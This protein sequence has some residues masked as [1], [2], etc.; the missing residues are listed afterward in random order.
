MDAQAWLARRLRPGDDRTLVALGEK[1][2]ADDPELAARLMARAARMSE[3][4]QAWS[5]AA[6]ARQRE[7]VAWGRAGRRSEALRA[8]RAAAR[9]ISQ[10]DD[11]EGVL[12]Y[13]SNIAVGLLN[14]GANAAALGLLDAV[15]VDARAAVRAG[16]VGLRRTLAAALVNRATP[17]VDGRTTGSP[18]ALLDEAEAV[19]RS[20]GDEERLGTVLVNRG[21]LASRRHD[22][23]AA[24][25]AYREAAAC[26]RRAGADDAEI[27]FAVRGEAATLAAVGRLDEALE[28]YGDASAGFLRSGRADEALVTEIGAVMARHSVGVRIAQAERDALEAHLGAMPVDVAGSLAMNLANIA[29][30]QGELADADRL[31]RRARSLFM[32]AGARTDV[33]RVDLGTA[34]ALRRSGRWKDA[35]RVI[36]R[37]RRIL[38]EEQR[39]LIVAHADHNAAVILR[40]RAHEVEEPGGPLA[41]RAAERSLLALASLD[42]YRHAL[43]SA[44]DRRALTAR[45]YPG[46]FSLALRCGLFALRPLEVAAVVERARVQPV[47]A[48][49][50]PIRFSAPAPIAALDGAPAVGANGRAIVLARE[51]ARLVGRGARWLGW[52]TE[53]SDLFSADSG[54]RVH[55][56]LRDHDER[57]MARLAAGLAVVRPADVDAADGDLGLAAELARWRALRGPLLADPQM[58]RRLE[59]GLPKRARD[60]VCADAAVAE[61]ASLDDAQL[62]WPLSSMLLGPDLLDEL[63]A[64]TDRRLR[65][66]IAPPAELGRVPWA[67]LPVVDPAGARAGR[68]PRLVD[69]AD[70]VV[71]MPAALVRPQPRPRAAPVGGAAGVVLLRDPTGDLPWTHDLSVPTAAVLGTGA[72][73]ATRKAVADALTGGAR[74]LVVA[75]HVEP[76]TDDDPAASALMLAGEQDGTRDGVPVGEIA[77][78]QVPPVCVL[79]V[80]DGAGAATGNEWTGVAT[81]LIW[82]GARWVV[83]TTWPILDDPLTPALDSDLIARVRSDGPLEGLWAWQRRLAA[84]WT[85]DRDDLAAAPYRWAGAVVIGSG[86]RSTARAMRDSDRRET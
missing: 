73:A 36:A 18:D 77:S 15:I 20:L 62:L 21:A 1:V 14:A 65:L 2:V 75:G 4:G 59:G 70:I 23:A 16:D 66:V 67:A 30:Q 17:A 54:G 78:L 43:P 80:C 85:S 10:L 46:M 38:V 69:R 6:A 27:A 47:L 40:Q 61:S 37:A 55:V 26:Y 32:R 52:W 45:T 5:H 76:G 24:R 41:R 57:A 63:A 33:A 64:A 19:L 28:R 9:A 60:A 58:A 68:V 81:G 35:L 50:D 3:R 11:V 34:V 56:A 79:L 49:R 13:R 7:V 74:M 53:G 29:T 48:G 8:A 84:R 42:R 86:A 82:A 12:T 25:S 71:G 39:W 51:A 44:A 83:A 22:L 72:R 31:R